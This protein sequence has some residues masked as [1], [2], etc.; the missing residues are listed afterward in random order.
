VGGTFPK[1]LTSTSAP[2]SLSQSIHIRLKSASR[3][4]ASLVNRTD[5]SGPAHKF[6]QHL[7]PVLFT[8]PSS[9]SPSPF[10]PFFTL[11]LP[12][13]PQSWVTPTLTGRPSIP[14]DC[15]RYVPLTPPSR[16]LG[17]KLRL[18]SDVFF[19]GRCHHQ[20]EQWSPRC[21]HG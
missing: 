21:T 14:S 16:Q 5:Y 3:A 1:T 17:G 10:S 20:G 18:I 4:Q 12:Y 19:P 9:S 6:S 7:R 8:S 11:N 13:Q 2:P 15:S